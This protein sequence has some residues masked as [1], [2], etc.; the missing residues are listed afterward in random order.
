MTEV[1]VTERDGLSPSTWENFTNCDGLAAPEEFGVRAQADRVAAEVCKGCVVRSEFCT[2]GP[3]DDQL[4]QLGI[5]S[6]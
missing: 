1:L 6:A 3:T 2:A 4:I 5:T